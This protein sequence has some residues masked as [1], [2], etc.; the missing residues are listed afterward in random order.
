MSTRRTVAYI[1]L[2]ILGLSAPSIAD[3]CN[4]FEKHHTIRLDQCVLELTIDNRGDI[5]RQLAIC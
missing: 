1:A 5:E 2:A 4:V 3:A